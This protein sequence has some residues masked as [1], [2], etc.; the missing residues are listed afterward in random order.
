MSK[1]TIQAALAVLITGTTSFL[2]YTGAIDGPTYF[3]LAILTAGFYF[4]KQTGS[5]PE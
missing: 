2:A 1:M 3:S 4:G 5:R